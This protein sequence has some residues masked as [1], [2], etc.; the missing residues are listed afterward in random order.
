MKVWDIT[1][2][3]LKNKFFVI[4]FLLIFTSAFA[5]E[6]LFNSAQSLYEKKEYEKS[7]NAYG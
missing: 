3:K 6:N 4:F 2:K 1:L 5:S 7:I